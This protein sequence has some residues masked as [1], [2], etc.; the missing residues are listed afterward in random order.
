VFVLVVALFYQ[1]IFRCTS[2]TGLGA[3]VAV[4]TAKTELPTKHAPLIWIRPSWEYR[5]KVKSDLLRSYQSRIQPGSLLL[6]DLELR[7]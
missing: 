5:T 3:A 7:M 4:Q 2:E 6:M 1:R